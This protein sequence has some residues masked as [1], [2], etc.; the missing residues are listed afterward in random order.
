MVDEVV[1]RG[2]CSTSKVM[3][4]VPEVDSSIR[5]RRGSV[6]RVGRALSRCRLADDVSSR[7]R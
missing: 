1:V 3:S 5:Q 4:A 7:A 6:E 2:G